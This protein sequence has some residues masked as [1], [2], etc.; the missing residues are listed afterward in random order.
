MLDS[1]RNFVSAH[2]E[3]AA[4]V[5]DATKF[6]IKLPGIGEVAV[7]PPD[8]IAFYGALAILAVTEMIPWP[9]AIGIGMG[10]A[11]TLRNAEQTVEIVS[12]PAALAVVPVQEAIE[13]KPE[14]PAKRVA[15]KR[16]PAKAAAGK[17]P[18]KKAPAR[19]APAKKAAAKKG[20]AKK[21]AA[22]PAAK[23][24][25]A[26]KKSPAKRASAAKSTATAQSTARKAPARKTTAKKA[27]AGDRAARKTPA[28]RSPA[29]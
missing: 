7:P 24:A 3:V 5:R 16:T 18:A 25:A 11:L 17:A 26:N 2:H 13:V 29:D 4:L 20:A 19:K 28:R 22:N 15:A 10:H 27:T 23:K 9:V 8:R 21:A 1:T 12:A 14:A 6:S